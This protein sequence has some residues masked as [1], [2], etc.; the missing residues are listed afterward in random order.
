[1]R[2]DKLFIRSSNCAFG[3]TSISFLGHVLSDKGITLNPAKVKAILDWPESSGTPAQ[4]KTQLETFLGLPDF[5]RRMVDHFADPVAPLNALTAENFEWGWS[6]RHVQCLNKLKKMITGVPLFVHAP[7]PNLRFCVETDVSEIVSGG[8][9][10]TTKPCGQTGHCIQLS[11]ISTHRIAVPAPRE[12]DASSG[13]S[14]ERVAALPA[15]QAFFA[16]NG[17]HCS[18]VLSETSYSTP[19]TLVAS[20]F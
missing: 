19:S 12:R 2:E 5:H 8:G 13:D 6:K 3:V 11:Q 14:P 10:P 16:I 18:I 17:Q 20:V 7:H 9:V 1:M 4:K 15:R